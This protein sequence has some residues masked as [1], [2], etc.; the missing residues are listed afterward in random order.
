MKKV[1]HVIIGTGVSGL[2]YA[3]FIQSEDYLILEKDSEPGGYCK[4]ITKKGFVWDYSGHFFHFR[5]SEIEQFL[6]ERMSDDDTILKVNKQTKINYKNSYIDFPFQKNIHQLNKDEFIEC[7]C[8]LF[9]KEPKKSYTDF[10]D[11]LFGKFG[12]G[13][14][15]KFL[16]PYNEK[17][18]ACSLAKLDS[19]AMG[20]FFPHAEPL[21]I[22][23]NFKNPDNNSYNNTFT[24]PTRG[25]IQYI[26]ALLKDLDTSKIRYN[27]KVDAI[28]LE[29]K[30]VVSNGDK[31]YFDHLISSIP[32][33]EVIKNIEPKNTENIDLSCNKVLVFNLGFN[34]KGK[35]DINW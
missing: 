27:T 34:K 1:K 32:F 28:N 6:L 31:I 3:N 29:R 13:I 23:N 12:K 15:E 19:E 33:N 21:D 5:N 14:T 17:L 20:R 24:Y 11:M 18:Y 10:E 35:K 25:A 22:I 2:S 16:K 7:L 30:F 8:D 9:S 26:N 4:T